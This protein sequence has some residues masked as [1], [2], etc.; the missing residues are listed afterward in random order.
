[1]AHLKDVDASVAARALIHSPGWRDRAWL[2][3]YLRLFGLTKSQA[4]RALRALRASPDVASRSD[5]WRWEY[6]WVGGTE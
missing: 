4:Q 5:G 2:S 3:R 1:M 6:R